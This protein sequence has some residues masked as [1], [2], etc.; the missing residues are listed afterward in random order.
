[1]LLA[2]MLD[3]RR[4]NAPWCSDDLERV[5]LKK[6]LKEQFK[7]MPLPTN[8]EDI[9]TTKPDHE[10]SIME[11][12]EEDLP[13]EPRSSNDD[14]ELAAYLKL[15]FD[16]E[17]R[18]SM[19]P[20]AWWKVNQKAFPR[21]ASLARKFLA[22]PAT[23]VPVERFFSKASLIYTNRRSSLKPSKVEMLMH[24]HLNQ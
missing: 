20:L 12:M 22:V 3:P 6:L 8:T 21:L 19:D 10:K 15:S 23:S 16:T 1:M 4:K 18:K 14:S 17:T 9:N 24:L 7:K 13:E 11:M 5:E 2:A